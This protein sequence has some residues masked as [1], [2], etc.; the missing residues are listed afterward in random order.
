MNMVKIILLTLILM[1]AFGCAVVYY[2]VASAQVEVTDGFGVIRND[3]LLLAVAHKFWVKEPQELTD[4]FISFKIT[5]KNRT[6]LKMD[7]QPE[8][9]SL[10][11]EAGNQYDAVL[12]EEILNLLIPEEILF[13][14]FNQFEEENSEIY[15]N[16]REAKNNLLIESFSYGAIL[17]Q[18]QKTGYIFFPRLT[19]ANQSC[20]VVY[21][22]NIVEFIRENK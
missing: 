16:W 11:D 17:P 8:D 2:P 3:S 21:N 18:A 12:Q 1:S 6:E 13:D 14:Q 4:Y 9:I 15:E 5:I 22:G 10:L 7:V 19:S 20:R